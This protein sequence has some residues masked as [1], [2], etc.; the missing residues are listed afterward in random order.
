MSIRA[1]I[2]H[3]QGGTWVFDD[4]NRKG[5]VSFCY[6]SIMPVIEVQ[7]IETDAA[8][9]I[10]AIASA[11][12]AASSFKISDWRSE[13]LAFFPCSSKETTMYSIY[14]RERVSGNE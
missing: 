14:G 11:S 3:I 13:S 10:A 5:L 6:Y 7:R 4:C 1:Y 9:G 8:P 12:S 2:Y